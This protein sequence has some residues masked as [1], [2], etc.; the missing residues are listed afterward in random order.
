[1][2]LITMK[3]LCLP[4]LLSIIA[5][6][7]TQAEDAAWTSLFDGQSLK[8]WTQKGGLAKYSAEDG[9]IV[10]RTVPRTPNSFLCT[11]K[12][13]GDFVLEYEFKIDPRLNSGVQIRSHVSDKNRVFGYQVEIDP[14]TERNR[15]WTAGIYDEGRR[16]WLND[17]SK[18]EAA[19]K[20]FKPVAWNKIRVRAFG[21]SIRTWLNDVPAADLIDAMTSSGFIGL[22]VHGIGNK[23]DSPYE[24][25]W[26][27]IRIQDLGNHEW[28]PFFDGKTLEGWNALPG[29]TWQVLDG[30]IVGKSPKSE[31]RHGIL[32]SKQAFKD[33]TA[34]TRFRVLSGDSGFYFRCNQVKG[35]VSV[36]GF[37]VEVDSSQET[38]GLYETGGRG[39]VVKPSKE[40]IPKKKYQPGQWTDLELSARGGRI[41]VRINGRKTA[42]LIDDPGRNEGHIGL[43]LHG[44]QDMHVEFK[45]LA[46]LTP[47]RP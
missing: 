27:N 39:W 38:G 3:K 7:S 36:H 15:M 20:A 9:C 18:N 8:G 17:L 32:L 5:T 33:F 13:Y 40:D 31:R 22:Q 12:N 29:G 6:I 26:R 25:R 30:A 21:D 34:R 11:K 44:G 2:R 23:K 19:R 46:V 1:M 47:S 4:V 28:K 14:D 16:G 37:Q 41:V 10:G 42:E 35:G 43:Q 45:D 24:V